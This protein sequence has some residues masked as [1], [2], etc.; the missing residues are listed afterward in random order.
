MLPPSEASAADE[1]RRAGHGACGP[2]DDPT[3]SASTMPDVPSRVLGVCHELC[4]SE[5]AYVADLRSLLR[6]RRLAGADEDELQ[7]LRT[8]WGADA[9]AVSKVG[10]TRPLVVRDEA[11][12]RVLHLNA[13]ALINANGEG[14]TVSSFQ[15]VVAQKPM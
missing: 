7:A 4:Y 3:S 8:S 10:V 14:E 11:T 2:S 5:A 6:E 15:K 12:A 1:L 9:G 13:H